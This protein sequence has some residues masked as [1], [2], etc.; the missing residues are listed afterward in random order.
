MSDSD[1]GWL[2]RSLKSASEEVA[3]WPEWKKRAFR[4][5]P[6]KRE[7]MT[8]SSDRPTVLGVKMRKSRGRD[9]LTAM[10]RLGRVF[11]YRDDYAAEW[12]VDWRPTTT[13]V[14]YLFKGWGG[15]SAAEVAEWSTDM[16]TEIERA[17]LRAQEGR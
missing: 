14:A 9:Y 2:M 17:V 11:V 5:L 10:T 1:D 7:E 15:R 16:L 13:S 3:K 4:V 6:E 8:M 12:V